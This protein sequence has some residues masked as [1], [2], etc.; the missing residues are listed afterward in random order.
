[1]YISLPL[2]LAWSGRKPMLTRIAKFGLTK[3]DEHKKA[4]DL[5]KGGN[6]LTQK[7]IIDHLLLI[8]DF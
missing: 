1:M 6:D 4:V 3:E 2:E 7:L 8:A 5:V